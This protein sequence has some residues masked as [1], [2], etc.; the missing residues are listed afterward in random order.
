MLRPKRRKLNHFVVALLVCIKFLHSLLS[1]SC[2][3][4]QCES[5]PGETEV[6]VQ[7]LA[8]LG[9]AW[10]SVPFNCNFVC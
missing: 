5:C 10:V 8:R 7:S 3:E 6:K 1:K 4:C 2:S 9:H